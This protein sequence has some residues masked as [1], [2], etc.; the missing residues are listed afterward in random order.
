MLI[1]SSIVQKLHFHKSSKIFQIWDPTLASYAQTNVKK[2]AFTHSKAQSMGYGENMA[3]GTLN[4]PLITDADLQTVFSVN[5]KPSQFPGV[6]TWT[7]ENLRFSYPTCRSG[8]ICGHYTQVKNFC[9][10]DK[11][12]TYFA[13]ILSCVLIAGLGFN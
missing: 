11:V 10:N 13:L 12:Q 9:K 3:A 7:D 4:T 2:C 5:F 6:D 8:K 1:G